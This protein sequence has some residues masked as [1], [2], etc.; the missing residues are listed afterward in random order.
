MNKDDMTVEGALLR[1]E[2][3][4]HA[5]TKTELT[6]VSKELLNRNADLTKALSDLAMVKNNIRLV[7][8]E[9]DGFGHPRGDVQEFV[10]RM[11]DEIR[12]LLNTTDSSRWLEDQKRGAE[13]V[14]E[15]RAWNNAADFVSS[16]QVPRKEWSL[17]FR[18][19]AKEAKAKAK[20]E[21]RDSS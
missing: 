7:K 21:S 3:E 11:S 19:K 9:L 15:W 16:G 20:E 8:A 17:F 14:G 4:S 2:Q 12:S 6:K 13:A 18:K 1:L 10:E 5:K